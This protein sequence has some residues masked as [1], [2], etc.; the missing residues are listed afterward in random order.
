MK[1]AKTMAAQGDVMFR[2]IDAL[3]NGVKAVERKGPV[4]VAHSETG[5]NHEIRNPEVTMFQKLEAD[6]LICF[7]QIDGKYADVVHCRNFD[8]HET[9]RLPGGG[10]IWEVR[11]QREYTPQG[12]RRVED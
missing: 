12:W 5:H 3:P 2:R 9:I 11:R 10:S 8:T 1:K 4:T 6:P 7:L